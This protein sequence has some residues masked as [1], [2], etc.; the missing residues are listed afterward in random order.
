M[1]K[2]LISFGGGVNSVAM[3]ILLVNEGWR[4]PIV[5]AD[6]GAEWPETYC[7]MDYFET[8]FLNKRNLSITKLSPGSPYHTAN[9]NL[10]LEQYCLKYGIIPIVFLRWCTDKYKIRPIDKWAK[11][12]GSPMQLLALAADEAHRAREG[13]ESPLIDKGID[14]DGCKK[15]IREAGLEMPS[16]SSCFFCPF[17]SRHRWKDLYY[18]HPDLFERAAALERNATERRGRK[19]TLDL[20]GRY[21]LDDMRQAFESQMELPGFEYEYLREFQGCVCGL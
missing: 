5:F 21:T 13:K 15:V 3:T 7:Y 20:S 6:T 10:P 2:E 8:E 16:K 4:G 18:F 11:S 17:Q 1:L 9:M 19:A 14:R 12:H